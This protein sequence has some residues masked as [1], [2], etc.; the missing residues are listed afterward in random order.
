MTAIIATT[1]VYPYLPQLDPADPA[2]IAVMGPIVDRANDIVSNELGYS[3]LVF[4]AY[5]GAATARTAMGE[6]VAHLAI[7]PHQAGSV[8]TVVDEQSLAVITGWIEDTEDGSLY[9]GPGALGGLSGALGE[10]GWSGGYGSGYGY[11]GYG[12]VYGPCWIAARRYTVTAK[13]GAGP[14]PDALKEVTVELAVNLWREKDRGAFSDVINVEGAGGITVG[15]A[16]AWT[17]RQ[18]GIL[19]ALVLKYAARRLI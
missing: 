14:V 15:Y 8:T 16:H 6:G 13:W 17:N 18:R 9:L 10:G 19:D 12:G 11:S 1:D 4:G 3:G 7:P 2:T 5:P